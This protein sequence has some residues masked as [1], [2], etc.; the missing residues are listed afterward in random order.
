MLNGKKYCLTLP[1]GQRNERGK[2]SVLY[3]RN[4]NHQCIFVVGIS[5][6]HL[7][8]YEDQ[9][10]NCLVEDL[11]YFESTVNSSYYNEKKI[12][13]VLSKYDIFDQTLKAYPYEDYHQKENEYNSPL[14]DIIEK[15][16]CK[17]INKERLIIKI[18]SG[19]NETD[20]KDLIL[21]CEKEFYS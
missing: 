4:Q 13:L 9:A 6:Y 16:K 17:V 12:I 19:L 3:N 2:L 1:G 10:T 15:F 18:M 5:Q 11:N 8:I 7:K 14:E 20:V 21:M